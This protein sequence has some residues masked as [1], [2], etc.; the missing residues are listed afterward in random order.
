[1]TPRSP[2]ALSLLSLLPLALVACGGS[3]SYYGDIDGDGDGGVDP[4]G[5]A[6]PGEDAASEADGGIALSL[7]TVW[8]TFGP[9]GGGTE[10]EVI[11]TFDDETEIRFD[12]EVGRVLE[13]DG[14]RMLVEVPSS[15]AEGWVDVEAVSG[16]RDAKLDD[17]FQYWADGVGMAGT[18][19]E[20]AYVDIVGDYWEVGTD[21]KY[22]TLAFTEPL[23]WELWRDYAPSIGSCQFE[24]QSGFT[25]AFYDPGAN[26]LELESGGGPSARL[27]S[28]GNGVFQDG[29]NAAVVPNAVYDLAPINGSADW[30][31]EDVPGIVEVPR[32]F[33]VTTPN[34]DRATPP[35][36]NR[37]IDLV[38][39]GSGGD[40]VVVYMLRQRP[41]GQNWIDDGYVTC[42]VPDSGAFTV[43]GAIWPNWSSGD[44]IHIQVG[45]VIERRVTLPHNGAESRMA[46]LFWVYGA[47][48]AN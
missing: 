19:G 39:G 34:M 11:G 21:V 30:P 48:L 3:L 8:P 27:D 47:A 33:S 38:W 37:S 13:R 17:G 23:D 32:T 31:V 28:Q 40:Y 15:N 44:L 46:G 6:Q 16:S 9:N 26:F 10:V 41:Q 25:P 22:A 2:S 24:F 5:P 20:M 4:N 29:P 36:T 12:G 35:N 14:D 43:P 42:A 18:V 1:M 7:D 45:R